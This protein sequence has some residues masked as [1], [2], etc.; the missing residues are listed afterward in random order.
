MQKASRPRSS[1]SRR[2]GRAVIA[3]GLFAPL[4]ASA[5]GPTHP[6]ASADATSQALTLYRQGSEAYDEGRFEDAASLLLKAYSLHEEPVILFN[7]ARVYEG[8]GDLP[9]ALDAYRAYLD[10]DPHASDR[11][12]IEQRVATLRKQIDERAALERVRDEEHRLAEE[13][14]LAAAEASMRAA[15]EAQNRRRPQ[16]IP[17]AGAGAGVLGIGAGAI[18]GAISRARYDSAVG[19]AFK[20][21]AE[22][23]YKSAQGFATA[24]NVAFVA[25][26]VVAAAGTTWGLAS[27]LGS[28]PASPHGVAVLLAPQF[29]GVSGSF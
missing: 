15:A 8:M 11:G 22:A 13:A 6:P 5:A 1:P 23:D 28:R 17:W 2:L 9:K 29:V 21:P 26:G 3:L 18:L 14:R 19:D 7:L 10:R 27:V 20:A 25:G 12:S 4:Q 24:A 16:W